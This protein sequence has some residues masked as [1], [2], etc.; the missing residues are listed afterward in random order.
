M[1]RTSIRLPDE[2][3]VAARAKCQ[4][5]DL[6]LSQVMR[7]LLTEWVNEVEDETPSQEPSD[8]SQKA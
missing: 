8:E 7:R 6:N 2:L 4:E 1:P 5:L 3:E